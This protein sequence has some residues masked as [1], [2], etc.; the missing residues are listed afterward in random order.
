MGQC[1]FVKHCPFDMQPVV[2]ASYLVNGHSY[3]SQL[4]THCSTH[5]ELPPCGMDTRN[6]SANRDPLSPVRSFDAIGV[7]AFLQLGRLPSPSIQP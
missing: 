3:I 2:Q 4:S 6:E 1:E 7:G 5:L